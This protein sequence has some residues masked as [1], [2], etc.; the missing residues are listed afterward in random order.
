MI[1]ESH[2]KK[3]FSAKVL[4][5]FRHFHTQ[6]L[7]IFRKGAKPLFYK[8]DFLGEFS[9]NILESVA[10]Y[11]PLS[12]STKIEASPP[13]LATWRVFE[14]ITWEGAKGYRYY[15]SKGTSIQ[16]LEIVSS[17]YQEQHRIKNYPG[18]F[19][20]TQDG[21]PMFCLNV[22]Y[23]LYNESRELRTI[24]EY[25]VIWLADKVQ[26]YDDSA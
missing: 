20:G 25:F 6:L 2:E 16:V 1:D 22:D 14:R 15:V 8:D 12:A 24:D 19:D 23:G 11:F 17:I 10:K 18:M 9:G 7:R 21:L 5:A 4:K 3:S 26:I 13:V